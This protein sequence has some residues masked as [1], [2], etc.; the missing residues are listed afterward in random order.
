MAHFVLTTEKTSAK[1][2]ARLFQ[3]NIWKLYSLP[4]SI[5]TD[6]R[7]QFAVGIM[8]ELN[9]MLGINTKLSITYHLQTDSQTEQINQNLEQYLRM[10]I[11]HQEQWLDWLAMAEFAYNNNKVQTCNNRPHCLQVFYTWTASSFHI[12]SYI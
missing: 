11:N 1:E 4:K 7:V 2:V 3:N 10:F 12:T 9:H 6:R 8:R 5:I